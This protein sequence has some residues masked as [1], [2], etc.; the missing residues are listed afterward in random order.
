MEPISLRTPLALLLISLSAIAAVWWW[1]ATPINLARAPIDPNAKLQCVSYAPFRDSQT[2]LVLTTQIAPEQIAEDLAQLAKISDC[3]RT[4]SIENG[5]D[6]VPALASKVGLKVIQGIWLGSNRLKNLTQISTAVRLAKEYPGVI[7]SVVVGNEVLLRGEMTTADLAA[8]IRSV[9]SQVM[10]PVT[11]ADVWEYWLRNRE[12]YEA[13]DFV[14]IHILPYWEDMPI[15][16]KSAAAHVDSIR[17]RMAVAFPGKEILIGE[18]GWPSEGRMREGALPSRTNQ[19]RVVSEILGLAKQENFR[20]NLIEAYDQPWKRQLEGTVGG[21]WGLI[22][23]AQRAVKYPPGQP[24]SN[25][26]FWKLQMACGMALSVLVFGAAWLTL[27]RRPWTPRVAS[28][29]A[30]GLS[31]TTAGF[32]LGIAVDKMFYESYGIGGWLGWGALLAAGIAS[33]LLCTNA[34]MSGR[35]LPTFLDLL[36][37]RDIRTRSVLTIML[38]AVLV[39]TTLI[40]TETALGFVFDPRY[41]DFPFAALTMAV[42]PLATLMLLNRP[43]EGVRPIAEAVFAGLL[44]GSALYTVFNEGAANWQ[45][46]WTCAVYA[47]LAVTLWRARAVRTPI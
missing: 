34:I 19:A 2:P 36:G 31:A 44:A 10:V 35:A 47:L 39:I 5:L 26:P 33:P 32:L 14:T 11:Y 13:V 17:K 38:G 8:T 30:V 3:V 1:L 24:I 22:D 23:A 21:Y 43:Q 20:V 29:I 16:A 4:Y 6:Q 40:G 28:W 18:T 9:K 12:I 45:S 15:R 42:V 46:I 25:F 27:R 41:R 37:P 7:T